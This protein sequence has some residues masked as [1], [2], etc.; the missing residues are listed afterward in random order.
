MAYESI[1]KCDNYIKGTL[2]GIRTVVVWLP[3]NYPYCAWCQ[4]FF[5]EHSLERYSCRLTE[6]WLFNP[7]KERAEH[8]PI[9]WEDQNGN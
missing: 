8:C 6:E 3:G 4:P 5:R 7:K 9:K 1:G 2:K